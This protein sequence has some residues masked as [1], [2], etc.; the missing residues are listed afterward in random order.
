MIVIIGQYQGSNIEGSVDDAVRAICW[1]FTVRSYLRG[2][3][4]GLDRAIYFP[5][6]LILMCTMMLCGSYINLGTK[7]TLGVI[8]IS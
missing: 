5:G 6:G 3:F 7:N 2:F 1:Q 4:V 8:M